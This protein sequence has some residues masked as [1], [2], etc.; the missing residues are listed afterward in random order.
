MDLAMQIGSAVLLLAMLVM[1]A[2]RVKDAVQNSP[3]GSNNDW[4]LA[5]GLLLAVAAFVYILMSLV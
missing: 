1:I 5:A 3:K 2:P 4:L